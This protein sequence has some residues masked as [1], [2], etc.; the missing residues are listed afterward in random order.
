ML[1]RIARISELGDGL[2][3][4]RIIWHLFFTG[5]DRHLLS[6]CQ[7]PKFMP[8]IFRFDQ[9]HV[10]R[11]AQLNLRIEPT[12]AHSRTSGAWTTIFQKRSTNP[13]CFTA[14]MKNMKVILKKVKKRSMRKDQKNQRKRKDADVVGPSVWNNTV[15]AFEQIKD[16]HQTVSVKIAGMTGSMRPNECWQ[17]GTC[18]CTRTQLSRELAWPP[19]I[20]KW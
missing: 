3:G 2:D 13:K 10:S 8:L 11:R 17:F 15:H 14:M 7:Q 16:A 18:E 5:R 20:N 9:G 19:A 4:M 6:H 12:V 1:A